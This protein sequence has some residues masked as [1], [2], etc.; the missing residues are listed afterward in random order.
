MH[1]PQVIMK[2][3]FILTINNCFD[4]YLLNSNRLDGWSNVTR[5]LLRKWCILTKRGAL[6]GDLSIFFNVNMFWLLKM[7]RTIMYFHRNIFQ[8]ISATHERLV[9]K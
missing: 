4:S 2:E 5:S 9:Q 1:D 8:I 7:K 6:W 3:I